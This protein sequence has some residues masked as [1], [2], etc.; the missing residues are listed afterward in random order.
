MKIAQ[1]AYHLKTFHLLKIESQLK[2]ERGH[3]YKT[4]KD[5]RNLSIFWL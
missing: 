2:G 3:I 5:A 1:Y 4:I